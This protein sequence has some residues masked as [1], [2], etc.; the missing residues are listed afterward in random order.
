[1]TTLFLL[2]VLLL[3]VRN[4]VGGGSRGWGGPPGLWGQRRMRGPW[5]LTGVN[6]SDERDALHRRGAGTALQPAKVETPLEAL[7][8]RFAAGELSIEA[9]EREVG[10]LYGVRSP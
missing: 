10:K 8:R 5:W 2:F 1:M 4:L 7:Q 6:E 3:V 9:Y